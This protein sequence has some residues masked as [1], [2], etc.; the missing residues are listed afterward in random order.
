MVTSL[1]LMDALGLPGTEETDFIRE[2]LRGK[3][4]L[5]PRAPMDVIKLT[6]WCFTTGHWLRLPRFSPQQN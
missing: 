6:D 3:N 1:V 2:V 4:R 5:V